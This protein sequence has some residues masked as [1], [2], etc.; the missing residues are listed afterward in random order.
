LRRVFFTLH[1]YQPSPQGADPLSEG[2]TQTMNNAWWRVAPPMDEPS[3]PRDTPSPM[4]VEAETDRS[5]GQAAASPPADAAVTAAAASTDKQ[6]SSSPSGE[7][8]ET[9]PR[10]SLHFCSKHAPDGA[11]HSSPPG[12]ALRRACKRCA[13]EASQQWRRRHPWK[14]IWLAF[15]RRAYRKFGKEQLGSVDLRWKTKG[16]HALAAAIGRA[17]ELEA[18]LTAAALARADAGAVDEM[19]ESGNSD[20]L[21]ELGEHS[22]VL[23]WPKGMVQMDVE[24]LVLLKRADALHRSRKLRA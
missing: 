9:S 5:D 17:A 10:P 6:P 19:S 4:E 20:A 24:Q 7:Q 16:A 13:A 8:K 2:S 12:S 14:T 18:P 11:V 15:V 22:W 1:P 3:N 21:R 23:T